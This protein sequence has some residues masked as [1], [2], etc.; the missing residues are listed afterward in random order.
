LAV[1]FGGSEQLEDCG[2]PFPEQLASEGIM[3][4]ETLNEG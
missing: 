4:M 1:V 3:M 2:W